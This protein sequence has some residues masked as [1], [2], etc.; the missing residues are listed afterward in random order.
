MVKGNFFL[1][2]YRQTNIGFIPCDWT[3]EQLGNLINFQG[4]SQ[5]PLTTFIHTPKDG[6]IR[7]LQIRDYKTDKYETY[8][9]LNLARKFCTE[10]DIMIGRYGPPIFQ[11]LKGLVGAYN[12]ALMKAVPSK[13]VDKDYIYHFL[14]QDILLDF[15]EKLSQRSSGQTGVDLQQLK[16]YP[17]ALPPNEE[18]TAIATALSN[19]DDLIEN[20]KKLISKKKNIQQ[21]VIQEFLTGK[22]RLTGFNDKWEKRKLG[23]IGKCFR[24]VSYNGEIDLSISDD[25]NTIRLFRSNNIQDSNIMYSDL[26][27]VN[28]KRVL[29]HQLMQN[30]DILICMANGSKSLV[31]KSAIFKKRELLDYTFGAFMGVFRMVDLKANKLFIFYN[32]QSNNYRNHIEVLLSGSSINNLK[33]SDIE[34]IEIP[35]PSSEEQIIIANI[36][37][38]MD[39]EIQALEQKLHKYSMIKQGMMQQLLT[40]KIRLI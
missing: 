40:G 26:Q 19:T 17:I 12:V 8:V 31:G 27:F 7:L 37:S 34:S 29:E 20:L 11:I 32:F 35:Y 23:E 13:Q 18:Q 16:G 33:P 38:D 28:E 6:Y 25:K 2:G 14:K 4:G 39:T 21:G 30:M 1:N 24:G 36:L 9:P 10:E 22:K 3:V 15:V 5:P